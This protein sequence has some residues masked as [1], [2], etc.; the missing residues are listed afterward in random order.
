MPN[1][2]DNRMEAER[3]QQQKQGYSHFSG[4]FKPASPWNAESKLG[5]SPTPGMMPAINQEHPNKP[6]APLSNVDQSKA[7]GYR[8][9][10][11]SPSYPE[12]P[13]TPSSTGDL[14]YLLKKE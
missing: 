5:M 4:T 8:G 10:L 2:Y 11:S 13:H 3:M 9:N 14:S 7:P 12:Q 6:I 1:E